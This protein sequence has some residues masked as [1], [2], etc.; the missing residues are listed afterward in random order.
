MMD[1]L[2]LGSV[3]AFWLGVLTSIS[4][5]PLATNVAAISFIGRRV[6]NTRAVFASGMLYTLGRILAYVALAALLVTSLL[7]APGVSLVLQKYMH[8]FIGPVLILLGMV[9]LELLTLGRFN[10]GLGASLQDRAARWGLCGA[11]IMGIIF[12]LTFCPVSAVLYFGNLIPLSVKCDS[13]LL[14]PGLYGLGTGLPVLAFAVVIAFG[15][16]YVGAMYNGLAQVEWWGRRVT[17][18]ILLLLGFYFTL[19]YIYGVPVGEWIARALPV[20]RSS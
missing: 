20:L 12:A 13:T 10:V 19:I 1:T 5:C 14:L 16:Q 3:S 15:A 4:P 8:K 6:G 7:S 11:G 2:L 17:G 18:V 9:L